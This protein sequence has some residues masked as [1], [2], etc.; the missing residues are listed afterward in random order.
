VNF[1]VFAMMPRQHLIASG[2]LDAGFFELIPAS[3][4]SAAG[5]DPIVV[6]ADRSLGVSEDLAPS[7]ALGVVTMPGI[8]LA[9]PIGP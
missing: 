5:L 6:R 1:R 8:P 2:T 4:L 3:V 9:A 7:G